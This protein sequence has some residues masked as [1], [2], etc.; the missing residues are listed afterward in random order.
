MADFSKPA[1]PSSFPSTVAVPSNPAEFSESA[2]TAGHDHSGVSAEVT[3]GT[4]T[5]SGGTH[6]VSQHMIRGDSVKSPARLKDV[7]HILRAS[8]RF[9]EVNMEQIE[10]GKVFIRDRRLCTVD[11]TYLY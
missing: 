11:P 9:A 2:L 5:P 8:N 7:R 10:R 4:T 3:G 1:A 6:L